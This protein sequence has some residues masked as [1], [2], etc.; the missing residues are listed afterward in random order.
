LVN[1][2]SSVCD[3][4][5]NNGLIAAGTWN[6]DGFG[7]LSTGD[8]L[9]IGFYIFSPPMATQAQAIREQRISQTIQIAIKLAGA[10]HEVDVIVNVNR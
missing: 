4:G 5:V 9:P 7:Q 8:Y 3:E 10:I 2:C 1:A 6:G